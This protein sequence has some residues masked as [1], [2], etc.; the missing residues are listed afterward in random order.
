[1]GALGNRSTKGSLMKRMV[2]IGIG[3]AAVLATALVAPA[4][5]AL[6]LA[7][8]G[9][10]AIGLTVASG[11]AALFAPEPFRLLQA[12][13]RSIFETRRAGLA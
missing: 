13:P 11:A 6:A 7:V 10:V 8:V 1:M 5:G 9:V 2:L 4:I 12:H 3:V